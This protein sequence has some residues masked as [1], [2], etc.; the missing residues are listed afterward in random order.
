MS[1]K[2]GRWF[3]LG[4]TL[5]FVLNLLQATLFALD[6]DEAYY[7]MYAQHLDWGYFDHPPAIALLIRLGILLLPGT[8]G[9]R[10]GVVLLHLGTLYLLWRL[11]DRPR[12]GGQLQAFLLLCSAMPFLHIYGFVST[13]DAPLLFFT[14][15]FFLIYR[16]FLSEQSWGTTVLLGVVMAALLYS[17]YH[18]VL[19]IFFT[20][21][22]NWR[23]LRQSRFYLAGIL[24]ALLFL[25]HLY[26]QYVHDFPTFRY[27]LSGRNDVYELKYTLNYLLNQL[28][29]F[30]PLLVPFIYLSLRKKPQDQLERAF[31]FV[32]GGFLLFFLYATRNGH[33]EPQWNAV[34]SIPFIIL[35]YRRFKDHSPSAKWFFR[36][37]LTSAVLLLTA[38]LL[39]LLFPNWVRTPF[40]NTAWV[41]E[42]EEVTEGSPVVFIDSYRDPSIFSFYSDQIAYT[43]TDIRYR[44]NQYDIWDRETELHGRSVYLVGPAD[45][46]PEQGFEWS[47]TRKRFMISRREALQVTHKLRLQPEQLPETVTRDSL[48]KL[49][50]QLINPYD[51]EIRLQVDPGDIDFLVEFSADNETQA[52]T[53]LELERPPK[54]LPPLHSVRLSGSFRVPK[55]ELAQVNLAFCLQNHDLRP[56]Y[57]SRKFKVRLGKP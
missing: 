22:S 42:L 17:K 56:A 31:Y 3:L 51:H 24:G 16:R 1:L 32:V 29:I 19:L 40:N 44:Q 25:P 18:G 45:W 33:V 23:L 14:V 43:Y 10:L 34:L 39:L 36:A 9:V 49:D 8:L 46:E 12:S 53:P 11:A 4:C 35:L 26:W 47:G 2:P 27:H 48:L 7:W 54:V 20:V 37:T 55:L 38:R 41:A 30:S 13:P 28:L 5:W 15:A 57:V 21:L 6:P 52:L 50:F